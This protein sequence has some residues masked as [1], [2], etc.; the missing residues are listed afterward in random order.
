MVQ[1][2]FVLELLM[3]LLAHP[4]GFDL[5]Y[6]RSARRIRRVVGEVILAIAAGARFAVPDGA[7]SYA[8]CCAIEQ[9]RITAR[10]GSWQHVSCIHNGKALTL[11]A[12]EIHTCAIAQGS[13]R[14]KYRPVGKGLFLTTYTFKRPL[15][16]HATR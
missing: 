4:A 2:E 16:L 12:M 9:Y 11:K 7:S 10:C 8:L 14:K 15:R 6:Q 13:C 3:R 1:T 5:T